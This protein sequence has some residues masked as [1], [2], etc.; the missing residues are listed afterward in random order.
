MAAAKKVNL[1]MGDSFFKKTRRSSGFPHYHYRK[2][3]GISPQKTAVA[4][5]EGG[6]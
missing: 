6:A 5:D 1:R 4:G 3:T 2:I